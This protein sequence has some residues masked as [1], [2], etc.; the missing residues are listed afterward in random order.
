MIRHEIAILT[1]G[2]NL[3]T[4]SKM[5]GSHRSSSLIP[6]HAGPQLKNLNTLMC[7]LN[8]VGTSDYAWLYT[9]R[10]S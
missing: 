1:S 6:I 8:H 5:R 4:G 10:P 9:N 7:S 3:L 2:Q